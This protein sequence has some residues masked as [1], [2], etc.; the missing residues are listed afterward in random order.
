MAR[1]YQDNA[2]SLAIAEALE[3][4]SN[5][6]FSLTDDIVLQDSLASISEYKLELAD[7]ETILEG[8]FEGLV[9]NLT[10]ALVIAESVTEVPALGWFGADSIAISEAIQ[11]IVTFHLELSDSQTIIESFSKA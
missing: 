7:I 5:I 3:G 8:I 10:D 4:A 6:G 1:I 11:S 2:D 9:V